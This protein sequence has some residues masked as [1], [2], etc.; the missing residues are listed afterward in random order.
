MN[1]NYEEKL[2]DLIKKKKLK[3]EELINLLNEFKIEQN[4]QQIENLFKNKKL[5]K[6]D[7]LNL[8][9]PSKK[10]FKLK[11]N[12][13]FLFKIGVFII[14]AIA[15]FMAIINVYNTLLKSN[16]NF[17]ALIG[18]CSLVG[19]N[20]I[21]FESFLFILLSKM[22]IFI[23]ILLCFLFACL[24]IFLTLFILVSITSS[25][26]D[27]Y[28][29]TIFKEKIKNN[30]NLY[31]INIDI[32][33]SEQ[34]NKIEMQNRINK[35]LELEKYLLTLKPE[36]KEY[37]NN[38]WNLIVLNREI[39]QFQ[40]KIENSRQERKK[41]LSENKISTIRKIGLYEYLNNVLFKN[42]INV[43]IVEFFQIIAP[44]LIYDLISSISLSLVFF[45]KE[46]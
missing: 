37:I 46:N 29:E 28:Q 27:R 17:H 12:K 33:E 34:E 42:K 3:K 32:K 38:N 1:N 35:R 14:F 11:I 16:D 2:N 9:A 22:K 15:F 21:C 41:L 30:D 25:Q 10:P 31:D 26:F 23:K 44:S 24:F 40:E 43:S 45:M 7:L 4:H 18:S 20:L 39:K 6:Q 19:F 8:F 13:M 36:S 5:T